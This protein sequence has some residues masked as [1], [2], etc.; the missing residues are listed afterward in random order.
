[1][2]GAS[3]RIWSGFAINHCTPAWRGTREA[4]ARLC[5]QPVHRMLGGSAWM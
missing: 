3:E 2:D 4:I 1:M 5:Y